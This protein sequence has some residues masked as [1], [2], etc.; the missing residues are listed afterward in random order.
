MGA[1]SV[2]KIV[3]VYG[4]FVIIVIILSVHKSGA[5]PAGP[6]A[7]AADPDLFQKIGNGFFKHLKLQLRIET[8]TVIN[9]FFLLFVIAEDLAR[10]EREIDLRQNLHKHLKPF[11]SL[12]AIQNLKKPKAVGKRKKS[13]NEM[14]K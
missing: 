9:Y 4:L 7:S 5:H 6:W 2:N 10:I 1:K 11:V 3:F 12:T 8:I 13:V 14:L